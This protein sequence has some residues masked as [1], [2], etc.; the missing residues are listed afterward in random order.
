MLVTKEQILAIMPKAKNV[1]NTYL[2]YLNKHMEECQINTPLRICHFL[3]QIALESGELCYKEENLNYS[4]SG[5]LKTFPKYF[6]KELANQYARKPEKI[7]NRVYANRMGNGNEASGDGWKY[8]GR[9]A[10]QYTGKSNYQ[11]YS[12][13]C[14]FDVINKPDLLTQPK[15]YIRS[16][17]HYFESRKCNELADKDNVLAI[18]KKINGGTNGLASVQNYLA[19]AKKVFGVE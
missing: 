1:V 16:A 15:G 10:I 8:R 19:K 6:T 2:S 11:E 14:G 17:C 3:A 4:A 7:A 12:K 5:L 18:R 13:W 9:G